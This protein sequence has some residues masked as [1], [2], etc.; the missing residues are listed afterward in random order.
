MI[1]RAEQQYGIPAEEAQEMSPAELRR[2]MNM[3]D[4]QAA[5]YARQQPAAAPVAPKEPEI[6]P[7]LGLDRA[8]IEEFD[9]KLIQAIRH[10]GKGQAERIKKLEEEVKGYQQREQRREADTARERLDRRFDT[11]AASH[12]HLFGQGD[13]RKLTREQE[14]HRNKVI[15]G[16]VAF[17]ETFNRLGQSID[18][19][20]LFR[21]AVDGLF[22]DQQRA[23]A[24]QA[25]AAQ[26]PAPPSKSTAQ[27]NQELE[28]RRQLY[29]NAALAAPTQ[30]H[31]EMPNG[32][33]KA[34]KNLAG[35]MRERGLMDP[36]DDEMDGFL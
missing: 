4:R 24:P 13:S 14:Q 18:E 25:Q 19:D 15:T 1:Q 11:V 35:N 7:D 33:A 32:E 3:L 16:M 31:G 23:A 9:P 12:G 20:E 17:S 10:V 26:Q 21:L 29:A 30:R 28:Q 22:R 6:D 34:V 27:I 36:E 5:Y 2:T 8:S